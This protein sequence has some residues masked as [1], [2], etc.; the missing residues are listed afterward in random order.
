MAEIE[1]RQMNEFMITVTIVNVV[2]EI[3]GIVKDEQTNK[4]I[5][6]KYKF[7]LDQ[8]DLGTKYVIKNKEL[9]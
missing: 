2:N 5:R 8:K 1:Y 6:N 4:E 3:L 7:Y 9:I